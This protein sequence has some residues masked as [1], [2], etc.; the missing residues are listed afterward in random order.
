MR[1]YPGLTA[2]IGGALRLRSALLS[3]CARAASAGAAVEPVTAAPAD[4]WRLVLAAECCALGVAARLRGSGLR[5]GLTPECRV[6][7][8]RAELREA[9][10]VTA[11]RAVLR[12]V[13]RIAQHLHVSLVVV[14]GGAAAADVSRSPVDLGDVDLLVHPEDAA[15]VWDALRSAGWHPKVDGMSPRDQR[16]AAR[17]HYSPLLPPAIGLPLELHH[18]LDYGAR[19]TVSPDESTRPIAGYAAL[20]RLTGPAAL[21]MLLRH[22]VVKHPL[23]RGHLR[24]LLLLADECA[25]DESVDFRRLERSLASDVYGP[26]LTDMLRQVEALVAGVAPADP[27]STRRFVAWKYGMLAS[28]SWPFRERLPGWTSVGFLALERRSLRWTEYRRLLVYAVGPVPLDSPLRR[29]GAGRHLAERSR[30]ALWAARAA[31]RL[32]LSGVLFVTGWYLRWL[33]MLMLDATPEGPAR[34]PP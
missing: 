5:N 17:N 3:L 30:A 26:E 33:T 4:V 34:L 28:T 14:K 13:D 10:R 31:Y 15:R 1:L 7:L 12:E 6:E 21:E 8:D 19:T 16:A 25:G 24:D 27:P 23:R 22:S 32:T 11:A 9:Q 2:R 20:R 29:A 18:N